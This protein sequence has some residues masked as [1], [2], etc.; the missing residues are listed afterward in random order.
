MIYTFSPKQLQTI[1]ILF[2]FLFK[3]SNNQCLTHS[4]PG[5]LYPKALLL[6]NT[7]QLVITSKGIFSFYPNLSGISSSYN[8]T[9]EEMPDTYVYNM[10]GTVNQNEIS[11]FSD[12][13]NGKKYVVCLVKYY[14]YL[15]D[16]KGNIL[17]NQ[18]LTDIKTE[19]TLSLVA[20]KYSYNIYFFV[21]ACN[22]GDNF[23]NPPSQ[24]YISLFYYKIKTDTNIFE[25]ELEEKKLHHPFLPDLQP[26]SIKTNALSCQ[27]MN[28][29]NYGKVL[30]CFQKIG[31]KD[32]FEG[33][34]DEKMPMGRRFEFN[35]PETIAYIAF[36]FALDDDLEFLYKSNV[37]EEEYNQ[38]TNF[39][40]SA[41][42]NDRTKAIICY[43]ES[44]NNIRCIYYDINKNK[45]DFTELDI[46]KCNNNYFGFNIY[47]FKIPNEYIFSCIDND[48]KNLYFTRINE[49]F[50]II[51]SN[52]YLNKYSF[53]N[54][55]SLDFF[56]IIYI[57]TYNVYSVIINSECSN[58]KNIR[59]FMLS[60]DTCIFPTDENKDDE[61]SNIITTIPLETK[62]H[63]ETTIPL[64]IT[65]LPKEMVISTNPEIVET[66]FP[67]IESTFIETCE[68]NR[69]IFSKGNCI[70]DTKKEYYY[71]NLNSNSKTLKDKC[72]KINEL[73]KNVYYEPITKSYELCYKTCATCNQGGS[74]IENN[75]LTCIVDYIFEPEKNSSNCVEECEYFYF[76]DSLNQYTCSED[77]QCPDG[78][79]LIIRDKNKCI[80]K[81]PLDGTNKYQYN[82]ECLTICPSDT[83]A[84]EN[85][86]C[87][88]SNTS[89]CT[90]SEFKLNLEE[91][92][93]QE[94]V[95]LV[96]K[97]YA[98]EFYYTVNHIAKFMGSDFTMA[99][100]KNSSC[101]DE[102]KLNITKIEYDSCIQQLKIDNN[103]DE[104]KELIVAVIDVMKGNNPITSFGF[105]NPDTG[106]KLDA[107][108]SCSDKSVKMY[109]DILTLLNDPLAIE[110][111]EQQKINIFDLNDGFYKDICF[112]F[113]SPNGK[114]AT[115]Q[116]RMKSFYPNLTL[117]N[118]G[119]K[120]KGINITTLRAECECTFQDLLSKNIF[121]NDLFGDNV[122][123]KESIQEIADMINN[124]NLE[125][126]ACYKDIFDFKYFKK[127]KGGFIVILLFILHT[128]CII[129]YSAKSKN[130][131]IR[132]I[133][134]ILEK[135]IFY[136]KK[137][138]KNK[139][140]DNSKQQIL[141]SPTKKEIKKKKNK[142]IKNNK[143]KND[144]NKKNKK[145]FKNDKKEENNK[146]KEK[147]KRKI[148]FKQINIINFNFKNSKKKK[149][150]DK[151]KEQS[152]SLS[153]RIGKLFKFN[154]KNKN[155]ITNRPKK[156][157][158]KFN[159]LLIK[160]DIDIKKY[161][162]QSPEYMEYDDVIEEDKRTFCQYICEKIKYNQLIINT[163]IINENIKPKSIKIAVFIVIIDIYFLTNGLFYSDS[164]ISEIFNSNKKETF[165]SFI[166]RAIDRF[167][168]TTII[169]N[170][171]E[172]IIKFF[173]VEEIKIKKILIKNEKHLVNL[174][175]EISKII[176]TIIKY[177][178]A[179]IIINY[180]IIIFSWYYLSCFNNIYPNINNEWILSSIFIIVVMQILYFISTIFEASLRF[181]SIKFESEKLFKLSL[182]L[183]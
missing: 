149:L 82:G 96:A 136:I 162:E 1:I 145:N 124:L 56:T 12:E 38:N 42:N 118:P 92:V 116:D 134:S 91:T 147:N 128:I 75:C 183:Y 131:M 159:Y 153:Q 129:V 19:Y 178:K 66:A 143:N 6:N 104:D 112:H 152:T 27:M 102:L 73:P 20:C 52:K 55:S 139:K 113:N 5:L 123:I 86:I 177:I 151:D 164:Y 175:Y 126:L 78:A 103:I 93:S 127:N 158:T 37:L 171:I 71:F 111:L 137:K 30:T 79:S 154:L 157:N 107:S 117:C 14:L 8:F 23:N 76:Y 59:I 36:N 173:F 176:K 16:E 49:N 58:Q 180:I 41:V 85:F 115:L 29:P 62:I 9:T 119:C 163:F 94:N 80:S 67:Y 140:N 51:D 130:T 22:I 25:L 167:I 105:F 7:F 47:Y 61:D 168:Y 99:L 179:L 146:K 133:Y 148:N 72:Y 77:E 166:P 63:L 108:K 33:W 35:P 21:I 24:N 10:D 81:C 54:C 106:E 90:S 155:I 32:E 138:K 109:E 142:E 161:L 4:F 160:N 98:Y 48:N 46:D 135:Y 114:D 169:V 74:S 170:V 60:N 31:I 11:Q 44:Y 68:D 50:E 17:F 156:N 26:Y 28:S 132:F 97:N 88:I 45:L 141:H 13:E 100:Y 2:Y 69:K 57:S 95:K 165:F 172:Y 144:S 40:K 3:S 64:E 110:L 120:N 83:N 174:K 39:F 121:E 122:F 65:T 181:L 43:L 182:L 150:N 87:Q 125:I 70:C 84:N 18:K 89:S 101:I 34:E 53:I 15:L